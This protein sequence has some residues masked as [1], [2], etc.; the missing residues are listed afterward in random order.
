V[1]YALAPGAAIPTG[2]K[3][4]ERVKLRVLVLEK[5]RMADRVERLK[6]S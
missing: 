5:D 4:G 1:T 2:L 3:A 6:G